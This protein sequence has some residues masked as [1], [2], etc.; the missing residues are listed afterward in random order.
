[1]PLSCRGCYLVLMRMVGSTL[2][3]PFMDLF[4]FSYIT[5]TVL[6]HVPWSDYRVGSDLPP[7]TTRAAPCPLLALVLALALARA[8]LSRKRRVR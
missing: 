1:M 7:P 6:F 4:S 3:S 2:L 5:C 8:A